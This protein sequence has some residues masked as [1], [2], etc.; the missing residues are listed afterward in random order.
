LLRLSIGRVRAPDASFIRADQIPGGEF[1]SEPITDLTPTLAVEVIS[2]GNTKREMEEKLDEYFASGSELVWYVYPE[3]KEVVV[4][5]S[6]SEQRTSGMS[7]SLD[8]GVVLPG[9]VVSV[10]DV[11]AV[12]KLQGRPEST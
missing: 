4:Y 7:D 2:P 12:T 3:R 8:G 6:R 10:A 5:T 9:F 1:P 11:F